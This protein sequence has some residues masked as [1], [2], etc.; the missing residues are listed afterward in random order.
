ML[1]CPCHNSEPSP[2]SCMPSPLRP[3]SSSSLDSPAGPPSRYAATPQTL[4]FVLPARCVNQ[5]GASISRSELAELCLACTR[6]G[7]DCAASVGGDFNA[8]GGG[9]GGAGLSV[10]VGIGCGRV[11]C[12]HVGSDRLGWQLVVS[13]ELFEDQVRGLRAF[14]PFLFQIVFLTRGPLVFCVLS[15]EKCI[16]CGLVV[17]W[18]CQRKEMNGRT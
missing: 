3:G 17:G 8:G 2:V 15:V 16:L 7:W 4:G 13:G 6:C 14:W 12:F 11:S 10:H 9:G 5:G 1:S 18:C